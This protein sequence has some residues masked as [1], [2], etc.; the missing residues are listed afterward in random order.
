MRTDD[1]RCRECGTKLI[2]KTAIDVGYCIPCYHL[3]MADPED[4]DDF[5]RCDECDGHDA[6]EDF[7][8][9]IKAGLGHLL[10]KPL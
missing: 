7:G 4:E 2:G 8:C 3:M 5:K 6:C 1:N 10:Q 9:A